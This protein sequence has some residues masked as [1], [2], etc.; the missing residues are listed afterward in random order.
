MTSARAGW[1]QLESG[2]QAFLSA[3]KADKQAAIA[4]TVEPRLCHGKTTGGQAE[5][6]QRLILRE[7]KISNAAMEGV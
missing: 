2:A 4:I 1:R 6:E 5:W 7:M 3:R